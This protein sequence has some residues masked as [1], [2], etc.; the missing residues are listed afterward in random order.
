[1]AQTCEGRAHRHS[2]PM[3]IVKLEQ[4]A[5]DDNETLKNLAQAKI[6][7][8]E[9]S[10]SIVLLSKI[11]E[12]VEKTA[13][14]FSLSADQKRR[15]NE[16]RSE[17][18]GLLGRCY[19]Q[20]YINANP[21]PDVP[22]TAD[23][24]KAI[25]YYLEGSMGKDADV[26]WH[27][28]NII[29]LKT[30][31]AKVMKGN[32]YAV[33]DEVKAMAEGIVEN[34]IEKIKNEENP[35]RTW[36]YSNLVEANLALGNTYDAIK[37]LKIYLS[38][39]QEPFV[40]QSTLRQF[41]E[42]YMLNEESAPGDQIIPMMEARFIELGGKGEA[43]KLDLGQIKKYEKVYGQTSYKSI[44][45]L[46][47][48]LTISK[49]I[50]RLGPNKFEGTGTGFVFE[51]SWISEK[52]KNRRFIMTNAHVCSDDQDVQQQ[53]PYPDP[54]EALVATFLGTG[55][56]DGAEEIPCK[57][58]FWTSPPN[59]LDATL[60][61]IDALP[62]GIEPLDIS[63]RKPPVTENGDARLNILGHP[64]GLDMRIS[65]QD[66]TFVG[67]DETYLWYKTPTDGGSSGSPVFDQQWKL[68]GLHHASASAKRANEGI[69]IDVILE[70][71]REELK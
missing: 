21:L 7:L 64:K 54:P 42:L 71:L 61:E 10:S 45:W 25:E 26:D 58:V 66:N 17:V 51:G 49:S 37:H 4:I 1:M 34:T 39:I 32:D 57:S 52:Y 43:T 11:Y 30:K 44:R 70:R 65:L 8:G 46:L 12:R 50:V 40:I 23:F 67:L 60:I 6:E 2:D 55:S 9:I 33:S 68:V 28:I 56:A 47:S 22:R 69:R 35:V 63:Y 27:N 38:L 16:M 29:A 36:H 41:K 53:I 14:D 3:C 62:N 31:E 5:I 19:K 18:L 24:E 15:N 20:Y 59:D 13:K 48:A